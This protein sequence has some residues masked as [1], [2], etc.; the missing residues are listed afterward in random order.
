MRSRWKHKIMLFIGAALAF[1]PDTASAD[2]PFK[3]HAN[4]D[5]SIRVAKLTKKHL[6]QLQGDILGNQ[7]KCVRFNVLEFQEYEMASAL[8]RIPAD[9]PGVEF[10]PRGDGVVQVVCGRFTQDEFGSDG[11]PISSLDYEK[12]EGY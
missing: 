10:E 6:A 2:V 8:M 9:R 7:G 3:E 5:L 1:S 12:I 4:G 11:N